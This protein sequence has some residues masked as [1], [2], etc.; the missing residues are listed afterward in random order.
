LKGINCEK[1]KNDNPLKSNIMKT[2]VVTSLF[3]CIFVCA[4]FGRNRP[5][6]NNAPKEKEHISVEVS[7]SELN[8]FWWATTEGDV[9]NLSFVVN[10]PLGPWRGKGTFTAKDFELATMKQSTF[11]I[12]KDPG[13][14]MLD[15]KF[16]GQKGSGQ[17]MFKTDSSFALYLKKKG[18]SNIP[19]DWMLQMFMVGIDKEYLASLKDKGFRSISRKQLRELAFIYVTADYVERM[20]SL[21]IRNLTLDDLIRLKVFKVD[22]AYINALQRIGFKPIEVDKVISLKSNGIDSDLFKSYR[23]LGFDVSVQDLIELRTLQITPE[24][25][26]KMREKGYTSLVLSDYKELKYERKEL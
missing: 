5:Y 9:V 10:L 6:D 4:S 2:A 22:T 8:G 13:T 25:I 24:Y 18:I 16:D 19:A 15:G 3:V 11:L 23:R 1:V 7:Q 17:F 21:G 20:V 12:T 14:M 26:E